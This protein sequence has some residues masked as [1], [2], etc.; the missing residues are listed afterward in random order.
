MIIRQQTMLELKVVFSGATFQLEVPKLLRAF[1]G[2]QT[3]ERLYNT[4]GS[5]NSLFSEFFKEFSGVILCVCVCE[6]IWGLLG[7]HFGGV[8]GGFRGKNYSTTKRNYDLI[9][10]TI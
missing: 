1:A 2:A 4:P 7:G 6:T 5:M 8:L 10:F 3:S 9:F